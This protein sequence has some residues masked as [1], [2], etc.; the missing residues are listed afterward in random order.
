M[1]LRDLLYELGVGPQ[2]LKDAVR[3]ARNATRT[4]HTFS[5][6]AVQLLERASKKPELGN[7]TKKVVVFGLKAA[8]KVQVASGA[9]LGKKP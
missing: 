1:N 4:V 7:Q 9:M 3:Q 6:V 5:S 2:D 8:E